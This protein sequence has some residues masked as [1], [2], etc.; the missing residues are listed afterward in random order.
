[1][2]EGEME[3]GETMEKM[4]KEGKVRYLLT[5]MIV[6]CDREYLTYLSIRFKSIIYLGSLSRILE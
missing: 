2:W 3:R 1:M 5:R 4:T 6:S